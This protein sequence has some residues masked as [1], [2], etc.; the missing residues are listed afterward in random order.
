[1]RGWM[2]GLKGTHAATAWHCAHAEMWPASQAK[3]LIQV[4]FIQVITY[5]QGARSYVLDHLPYIATVIAPQFV[6]DISHF[7]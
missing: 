4:L 1:M 3:T 2:D 6:F 5:L 7:C